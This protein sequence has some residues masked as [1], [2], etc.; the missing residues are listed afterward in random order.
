MTQRAVMNNRT[1]LRARSVLLASALVAAASIAFA[2]SFDDFFSAIQRDDARAVRSLLSRGFDPDTRNADGLPG[3]YLALRDSSLKAAQALIDWPR[4]NLDA[5]NEQ[6]ETPLMIAALK[7]E[8]E[9]AEKLIARDAAV[10]KTGWTPLHYAATGGHLEIIRL[11]LEH[12][13]YIDAESPNGTTPLMMAARYGSID[14]VRL[15]LEEGADPTPKNQIGLS[16]I[17]F[18]QRAGK[19]EAAELVQ[20]AI[21]ARQ[22]KGRQP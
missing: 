12:H 8:R 9:I 15:L 20:D 2:G 14:A 1:T 10:N 17:D 4:I 16:A 19:P 22:L 5:R 7:G 3:L 6:D 21:R 13:A 11:L 18:A